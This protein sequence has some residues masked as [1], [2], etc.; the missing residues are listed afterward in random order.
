MASMEFLLFLG[1]IGVVEAQI[2]L[3]AEFLRDAEIE[4][5]GLG[6]ADVEIAVGLRRKPVMIL[7]VAPLARSASTMSRM[8]SRP[9]SV[10]SAAV[11][12]S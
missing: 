11:I 12:T 10:V 9:A 7:R 4:G 2:A 8:K 3:A 1:R 6:V 5:D